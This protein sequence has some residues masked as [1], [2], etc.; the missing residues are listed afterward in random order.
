MIEHLSQFISFIESLSKGRV[1]SRLLYRGENDE[2]YLLIPSVYRRFE[3]DEMS[4]SRYLSKYSEKY[5]LQQFISEA[6]ICANVPSIENSF[7]W[8]EYAQHYG[9]PTRLLDWTT[10][11]LVALFFACFGSNEKDGKVYILHYSN[12]NEVSAKNGR[13]DLKGKPLKQA[14][15]DM[16]W[17]KSEEFPYP[18]IFQPYY[19]DRR[20]SAQSS[21]FM[22]WGN[23]SQPL[24]EMIKEMEKDG[25]GH[26]LYI[27]SE[28]DEESLVRKEN[29]ALE[30]I[31]IPADAKKQLL[32]ELDNVGINYGTLFP[33]LDGIGKTIEWRMNIQNDQNFMNLF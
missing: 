12:Y 19:L 15:V 26:E 11:P 32:Y 3:Q 14:V 24:T 18:I 7:T 5:I 9:V 16:I 21:M 8:L 28:G 20:M 27:E 6:S 22:V 31:I 1:S 10:N 30:A 4:A 13:N 33:G 17:N 29:T 23:T 25:Y 2:N